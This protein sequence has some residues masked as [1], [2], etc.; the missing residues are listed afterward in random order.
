MMTITPTIEELQI[1]KNL[2]AHRR[3]H[4]KAFQKKLDVPVDI[5]S[6][7]YSFGQSLSH[8]VA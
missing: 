2:R 7:P 4:R 5:H 1:L 8:R 6:S 3:E